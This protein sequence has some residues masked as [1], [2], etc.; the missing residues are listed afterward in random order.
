[1]ASA[2]STKPD[3]IT[4]GDHEVITP[5][6][7]KLRRAVGRADDVAIDDDPIARAE[8]ALAEISG[9]FEGWMRA[10]CERLE[11]ARKRLKT[12][13]LSKTTRQELFLSAHDIKGD[14]A[15]FGY[16]AV[17]PAAESLCRLLEHT[18]D[19]AKIPLPLIDQHVD[20]VRA[21]VREYTRADVLDVATALT[22][23]L[24]QV[25]DEFLIAENR[26]RPEYL[27]AIISPPLAPDE[28]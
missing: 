13:G 12:E 18:P 3:V 5:D 15:T 16:P 28:V 27:Q 6:T 7:R 22:K 14:C 24:R 26:H 21:I 4:Y 17:A 19:V 9:E 8:K 20:A 10:E 23:R 2:K 1:M 11:A 25:A